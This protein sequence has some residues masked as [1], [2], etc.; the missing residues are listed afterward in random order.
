M[1]ITISCKK[2]HRSIDMGYGGFNLLRNKVA[3]L[4][5]DPWKS[6]YHKLDYAPI[7]GDARKNFYEYF[8]AETKLL[9]DEKRYP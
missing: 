9:L 1:G 6:H 7:F 4:V 5:G 3:D 8:D 2:T